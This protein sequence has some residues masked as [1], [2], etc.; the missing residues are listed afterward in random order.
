MRVIDLTH[1]LET[2]MPVYPGSGEAGIGKL[3]SISQR[4]YNETELH[5]SA[6]TGTHIDCGKHFL[7]SGFDTAL[8]PPE[9][10]I[11]EG[12]VIDCRGVEEGAVITVV[13]LRQYE[14]KLKHADFVLL[15]TGWS[16]HWGS[17]GYYHGFPVPDEA[18]ARYLSGFNLKGVGADTLSF[19]PTGS[20]D[21]HVHNMLLSAGIALIEN[22]TGLERLPEH[23]FLFC[24]FPLKIKDGD[25][26]PVRAVGLVMSE[27]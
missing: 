22:L 18:A 21:F 15:H 14:E 19:D 10:F 26:S 24:C 9:R 20:K 6:H 25:G 11:G 1:T 2:G 4:G 5:L 17:E 27:E 23:H 7:E 8:T 3:A 12:L 16:R 13:Q